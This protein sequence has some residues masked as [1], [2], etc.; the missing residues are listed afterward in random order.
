VINIISRKKLGTKEK[1]MKTKQN[2]IG[3]EKFAQKHPVWLFLLINFA[4]TWAFWLGA[5]P[6][7]GREDLLQTVVVI[8]GGFG[9]ALAGVL[10]LELRAGI[11]KVDLSRER[12]RALRLLTAFLG[13]VLGL[14]YLMGNL[15]GLSLLAPNLTLTPLIAV[16]VLVIIFLGGWVFSAADSRRSAVESW[17]GGIFPWKKGAFWTVLAFVFYPLMILAA[18]GLASLVGLGVEFPVG[19]GEESFLGMLLAFVA[20][21]LMTAFFQGGNEEPGWRGL[22]QPALEQKVSPLVA[23]LIVAVFWSLWHLPLYLNGVYPGDLVGGMLS[24]F[25]FRIML[26]IFLAWFYQRSGKNLFAMMVLHANFNMAVNFLPTSDLGLT[27]LW[28]VLDV[29]V[30]IAGKLYQQPPAAS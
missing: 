9:P 16:G 10:T 26:S 3:L 18:W 23:A 22:M 21:F 4:W 24:G 12:I 29:L 1:E 5:I 30:I 7:K 13:V 8:I 27:I 17:M 20:I 15:T 2:K 11:E 19:W 25:I 14:R 28:V 6:L